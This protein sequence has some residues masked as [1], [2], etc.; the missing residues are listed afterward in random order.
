MAI[1]SRQ[2]FF[3]KNIKIHV[4]Y[5]FLLTTSHNITKS[6]ILNF[7][8]IFYHFL[9]FSRKL[10]RRSTRGGG[11]VAGENFLENLH[12]AHGLCGNFL[13]KRPAAPMNCQKGPLL[14]KFVKKDHPL[15]AARLARRHVPRA[16]WAKDG[17]D[18]PPQ[19]TP[20]RRLPS[21]AVSPAGPVAWAGGG[22]LAWQ[23]ATTDGGGTPGACLRL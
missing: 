10:K 14:N 9:L 21:V 15:V 23:P 12:I 6:Q 18:L 7:F 20:T 4:Y 3:V 17:K 22:M 2:S 5:F 11:G 16:A 19:P 13:Q 8:Q 1:L